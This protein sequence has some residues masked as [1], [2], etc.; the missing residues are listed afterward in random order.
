M[1]AVSKVLMSASMRGYSMESAMQLL[2]KLTLKSA[3]LRPWGKD[4]HTSVW[5]MRLLMVIMIKAHIHYYSVSPKGEGVGGGG[6]VPPFL[7]N[8]L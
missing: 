4:Q 6:A 2:A 3:L 1:P 5:L 7:F 8:M